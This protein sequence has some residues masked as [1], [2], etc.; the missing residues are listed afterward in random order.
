MDNF[1]TSADVNECLFQDACEPNFVCNN[2]VGS[3]RCEKY[4]NVDGS[5]GIP[6]GPSLLASLR[7]FLCTFEITL[8]A[9]SC[10]LSAAQM[11]LEAILAGNRIATRVLLS[12]DNYRVNKDVKGKR[13]LF[14]YR[15]CLMY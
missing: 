15:Y 11:Q 14:P 13:K 5:I 4:E 10:L 12:R 8:R 3:Y 6:A 1:L 7:G 9:G 2:T